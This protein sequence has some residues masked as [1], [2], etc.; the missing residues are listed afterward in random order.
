MAVA[1]KEETMM[2]E[3]LILP[4]HFVAPNPLL[5]PPLIGGEQLTM[6]G[7]FP[8]LFSYKVEM[9]RLRWRS[10]IITLLAVICFTSCNRRELEVM[11]P[12]KTQL[13]LDVDWMKYFGNK[14]N[15]M[16]VMIWG[17]GWMRPM[18]SST[19]NVESMP[20]ELDPGHYRILVFNKSFDEFGTIKFADTDSFENISARGT[21]IT[22]YVNGP[23]DQGITY[24]PD[25]E[26]IGC[27][28][29]EFTVTEDMLLEQVTFYPYKEWINRQYA[30]T[31]WIQE[32]NGVYSTKVDVKPEITHLNVYVHVKGIEY[33]SSII[34]NISGMADGFM[35]SQ[36]WRTTDE[37]YMLFEREKWSLT[38][39]D[40]PRG[41]GLMFYSLPVFGLPHGKELIS[42][43]TDDNNVLTLYVTLVDGSSRTFTFNVG[44]DITYRG[45]EDNVSTELVRE[46]DPTMMLDLIMELNLDLE[47]EIELPPVK[48]KDES[49][50]GFD[51]HV[52]PWEDGGIVDIGF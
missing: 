45:L 22:Q 51:A 3:I 29:D 37:R 40:N 32:S 21:D 4:R 16:T 36:V 13:R 43:R 41:A 44:K 11:E 27:A 49:S 1:G 48:P 46:L 47:L 7:R 50:S 10:I 8:K 9:G 15:G 2:N 42:Q 18:V 39:G 12:T 14:P 25:P 26:N 52:D 19:N 17:D 30:N 24:M 35:M 38:S 20:I 5:P 31:R 23:W 6:R 34:G 33:M 28:V